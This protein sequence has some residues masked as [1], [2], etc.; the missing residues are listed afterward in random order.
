MPGRLPE[1]SRPRARPLH[2]VCARPRGRHLSHRRCHHTRNGRAFD[3][4]RGPIRFVVGSRVHD[5][6][7]Y[8][9]KHQWKF[10]G[11]IA[12]NDLE[13]RNVPIEVAEA[14]RTV[15]KAKRKE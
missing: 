9:P 13:Q 5:V 12:F 4:R 10:E 6:G 2:H 3:Y 11:G 7:V 15:R 8:R 1:S 14:M